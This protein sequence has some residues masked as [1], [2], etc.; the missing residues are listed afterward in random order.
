MVLVVRFGGAGCSG[1]PGGVWW[2]WFVVVVV[3]LLQVLHVLGSCETLEKKKTIDS[4][5]RRTVWTK[6][7]LVLILMITEP[8]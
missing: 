4:K 1:C 6:E 7:Y 3:V 8:S 5:E 2:F